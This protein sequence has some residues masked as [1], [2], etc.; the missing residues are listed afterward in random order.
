MS[1]SIRDFF[2]LDTE[3]VRSFIAQLQEGLPEAVQKSH[4]HTGK[5]GLSHVVRA[6]YAMERAESETRSMHHYLYSMLET[7]LQRENKLVEVDESYPLERWNGESLPDGTLIL[8]RG[9]IQLLD[10]QRTVDALQS[11]P[12]LMKA[13]SRIQRSSLRQGAAPPSGRSK[14]TPPT[15]DLGFDPKDVADIGDVV[16][17]LYGNVIRL[18]VFPFPDNAHCLAANL[19]LDNLHYER[20]SLFSVGAIIPASQWRVMGIVDQMA[21]SSGSAVT[22]SGQTL[23][24]ILMGMLEAFSGIAKMTVSLQ[25][26][27]IG[28]TPL[29]I[30]R[31]I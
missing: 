4:T 16:E 8:A 10:V 5:G 31:L 12:R 30:Y 20:S 15:N 22:G 13:I 26:P 27:V 17:G 23:E 11:L 7:A 25:W 29:A 28:L 21:V 14:H 19:S 18:R 24:D 9:R 6:E 3:R 1:K 2:Y